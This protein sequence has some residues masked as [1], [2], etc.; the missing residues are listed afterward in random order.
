VLENVL[1]IRDIEHFHWRLAET[2]SRISFSGNGIGL[3]LAAAVEL[4]SIATHWHA[5]SNAPPTVIRVNGCRLW[6]LM[7]A[8]RWPGR[9]NRTKLR[10][11]DLAVIVLPS[12]SDPWWTQCLRELLDELKSNGFS[13]RLARS[14]AG[15]VMEMADNVWQHSQ[16]TLPGLVAYQIRR[17]R[18]AFSVADTGIGILASLRRN[19][20]YRHLSSSME[21]IR[22]AIEPGVSGHEDGN[23][24]GYPSLLHALA[25]LWGT[26]RI[27]SGEAGFL[28]DRTGDQRRKQSVYL[29]QLP[30]VHVSVRC[31]LDPPSGSKA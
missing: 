10:D 21:A 12:T 15:A 28:I 25:E 31:G 5:D 30:G 22:S 17:R 24:M 2:E 13:P 16:S 8:A 9:R 11:G 19:Q 1:Q 18:F 7:G 20:Q 26:A 6:S 4:A 3:S 23:G 14:L 27:R 29:P